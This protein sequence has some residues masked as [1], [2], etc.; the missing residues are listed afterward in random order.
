M[1]PVKELVTSWVQFCFHLET[2]D[3]SSRIVVRTLCVKTKYN[4]RFVD[5][6]VSLIDSVVGSGGEIIDMQNKKIDIFL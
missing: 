4:L 2:C 6:L 5:E 1:S 3:S